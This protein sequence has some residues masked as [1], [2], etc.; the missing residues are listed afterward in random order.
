M[1]KHIK[2]KREN[3]KIHEN[4]AVKEPESDQ[5]ANRINDFL[6]EV[7]HESLNSAEDNYSCDKYDSKFTSKEFLDIHIRAT[8]K[9]KFE[10]CNFKTGHIESQ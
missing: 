7:N 9:M 8:H 2:N 5:F 1:V 3:I 6:K 10:I 4:S